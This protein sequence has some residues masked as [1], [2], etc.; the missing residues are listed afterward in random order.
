M[1]R[2][3]PRQFNSALACFIALLTLACCA[4]TAAEPELGSEADS[5]STRCTAGRL[6]LSA[7]VALQ[8]SVVLLTFTSREQVER[9]KA[10]WDAKEMPLWAEPETRTWKGL[11]GVDLEKAAGIYEVQLSGY[12]V[13]G[14]E[15][16]CSAALRVKKALFP[17]EKLKVEKQFV[18]P[19]AE[20]VKRANSEREKLRGIFAT[21]TP[22]R[23]WS[24]AFQL[25]LE[26]ISSGGN[27]GRRRVLNGQPG[28]PHSGVDFPALQGT[29]VHASQSG[30]VVLAQGLF[31]SG[32]TV[33]LDHGLGLYTFYGHL[34]AFAVKEG[35]R[36]EAGA[37]LGQVGATGRVTGPHLHWGVTL[38]HERV[39]GLDLVRVTQNQGARKK[40]VKGSSIRPVRAQR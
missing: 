29:P 27:F 2:P 20:Q 38:G 34:S 1:K 31:F 40:A 8:G 13:R 25:P 15:V 28:S 21:V 12:T 17:T 33:V 37:V 5:P 9:A 11:V 32:N 23:L 36:V 3:R 26:G 10:K 18:E 4:A 19:D 24:G 39:N 22:I 30:Q 16:N 7:P 6:S 35:D 14:S